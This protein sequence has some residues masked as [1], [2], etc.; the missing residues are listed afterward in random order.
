MKN[1]FI[2]YV[3][4]MLQGFYQI[5]HESFWGFEFDEHQVMGVP[6]F[7]VCVLDVCNVF[8]C[9]HNRRYIFTHW[10]KFSVESKI[11]AYVLNCSF[12]RREAKNNIFADNFASVLLT[13]KIKFICETEATWYA[14]PVFLFILFLLRNANEIR[15]KYL[16]NVHFTV[17]CIFVL[18][19]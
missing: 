11:C 13:L 1:S 15:E 4:T 14:F 16:K 6:W 2:F 3:H 18:L 7:P 5:I 12:W 10:I 17:L 19:I 9:S 8:N